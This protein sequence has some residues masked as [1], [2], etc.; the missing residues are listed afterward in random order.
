M[1][2]KKEKKIKPPSFFQEKRGFIFRMLG[3]KKSDNY[4]LDMMIANEI[5]KLYEG[6]IDFLTKVKPPFEFKKGNNLLYFRSPHGREYL[7]KKFLEFK[8]VIPE[9]ELPVDLGVKSGDDV[10]ESSPRTIREFLQ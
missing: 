2:A 8:F 1:P 9:H 6:E 5:F 3:G 10:Y 4:K 7:K